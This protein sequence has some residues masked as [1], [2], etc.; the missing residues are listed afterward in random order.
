[1]AS[2]GCEKEGCTVAETGTCLLSHPDLKLCPNFRGADAVDSPIAVSAEGEK[3]IPST[4]AR[5]FPVGLE[6]GVEDAAEI[7]ARSYTHLIGILGSWDAGKT[8]FILSL[9]MMAARGGLPAGYLFAESQTLAGLEARARRLREWEGGPLPSQFADHTI[10]SDPRKPAF[11]HIGLR[12]AGNLRRRFD[13][14]LTDLPGEW[15]K[16][17]V[18]NADIASNFEFLRR[19][20]GIILVVEGPLLNSN[21][22][23]SEVQRTKHLMDRLAHTIGIDTHTPLVLLVSKC[24]K[25]ELKRPVL[26]DD[27]EQ[28]AK[29]LGFSPR[30]ILCAAFSEVPDKVKNGEGVFEAL[31]AILL[32]DSPKATSA[33]DLPGSSINGRAFLNVR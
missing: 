1:M 9:Y 5:Q 2:A 26:V 29:T 27:L 18:D 25:L 8:C 17:L 32:Q 31:E 7:M 10:N 23:H 13:V 28:H 19:A 30:V 15:S 21:T 6:L 20:D 12:E 24:D 16:N 3:S 33:R 22:R 14:V 11:L 4:A